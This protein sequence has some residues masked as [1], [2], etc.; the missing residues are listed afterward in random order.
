LSKQLQFPNFIIGGAPKCGTS[1]LYFWLSAHP[2]ACS[3]REKETFYFAPDENRF[4]QQHHFPKHGYEG[5]A[6]LFEHCRGNKVVF[7]AT[8]PY[9]YYTSAIE[10]LKGLPELP[11]LL[12]ILREPASRTLSQ[13][14]FERYRTGRVSWSYEGYLSEPGILDHGH[15][16][17]Y[18]EPWLA[19]FGRDRIR[20]VLFEAVMEN[21]KQ[22]MRELATWL[23]I[24]PQFY[25]DF[26]FAIRNETVAIKR[27]MLHQLGL[28]IQP[29]VPHWMQEKLLPLYLK[30]NA[31]KRPQATAEERR[32]TEQLKHSYQ[33]SNQ[34]LS[35]LFP[36]LDLSP[37]N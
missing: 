15:Y 21:P 13:Y 1:S 26:D 3:S 7:E 19:S 37:W 27:K 33:S 34:E 36:E 22:A 9:I 20:V 35:K 30:I 10:G 6:D 16:A 29:W 28:R 5:Y 2:S 4:N 23:G 24:D 11:R 31:G 17:R 14:L 25:E 32:L 8:A 18:L 12:F